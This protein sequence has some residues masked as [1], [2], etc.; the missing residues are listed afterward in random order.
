MLL[1]I[2]LTSAWLLGRYGPR[3]LVA[4][5]ATIVGLNLVLR[6]RRVER[7]MIL[8]ARRDLNFDY[9]PTRAE[10]RLMLA[11]LRLALDQAQI[12]SLF[13]SMMARAQSI[14]AWWGYRATPRRPPRMAGRAACR[15]S[16][17]WSPSDAT[18]IPLAH[19]LGSTV[20]QRSVLRRY[21][22]QPTPVRTPDR[23][24]VSSSMMSAAWPSRVRT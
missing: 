4:I 2:A 14:A 1:I 6:A 12:R 13:P 11:G 20:T 7:R 19:W 22:S 10:R 5:I 15:Q 24:R 9:R 17:S 16:L 23:G 18:M 3:M 8:A 21:S